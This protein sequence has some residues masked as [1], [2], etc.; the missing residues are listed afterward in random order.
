MRIDTT[1]DILGLV[2]VQPTFMP[3]G[4]LPVA[5]GH[6]I[7]PVVNRLLQVFPRAFATQDW[8]PA[9]HI[10]FSS[11]HDGHAAYDMIALPYGQ[12]VLWPDHAVAGSANAAI[13]PKMKLQVDVS[14]GQ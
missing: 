12:Q 11:Q 14:R 13:H 10:S 8:H 3:G 5:G 9:N 4:E 1:R 2:D 7:L 6:E